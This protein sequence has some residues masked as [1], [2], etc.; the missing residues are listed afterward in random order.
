MTTNYERAFAERPEVYAAWGQLNGAI[1]TGM[2]WSRPSRWCT[3][4]S[5][6]SSLERQGVVG[7]GVTSPVCCGAVDRVMDESRLDLGGR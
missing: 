6:S 7:V 3:R 1:K 4:L 2:D 5:A